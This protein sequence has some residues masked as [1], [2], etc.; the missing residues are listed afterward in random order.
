MNIGSDTKIVGIR[1]RK[2]N[3]YTGSNWREKS[4]G[5]D[6]EYRFLYQNSGNPTSKEEYLGF[7]LWWGLRIKELAF[8]IGKTKTRVI[9]LKDKGFLAIRQG[10]F[11]PLS[12]SHTKGDLEKIGSS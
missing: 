1:Y 7:W 4:K 5:K 10:K 9:K 12:T 2:R 8:L 3:I 6:Y 11:N